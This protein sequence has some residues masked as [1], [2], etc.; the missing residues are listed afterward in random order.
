MA[1]MLTYQVN[2]QLM[3]T[4][5]STVTQLF[6]ATDEQNWPDVQQAFAN[7]VLLDYSSMSGNP[8]STLSPNE[9]I[10]AWKSLLPGFDFTHHQIGNIIVDENQHTASLFCYGTASHYLDNE[11]ENLWLV[12]GTYDFKLKKTED[13]NWEITSMK[14]NFKFQDGNKNLPAMAMEKLK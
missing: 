3:K 7:K 12:V 8:S 2:A 6:V 4:P 13:G 9:I 10:T 11:G 14:F 1:I 5:E